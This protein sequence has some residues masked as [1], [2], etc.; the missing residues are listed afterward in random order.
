MKL[1]IAIPSKN[2][3]ETLKKY[4]WA[5]ARDLNHTKKIFVEPQDLNKYLEIC[6]R[7]DIVVLDKD[8]QG[9][10]Y[11][12]QFIQNY[13]KKNGYNLVFK[14]DDDLRGMTEFRTRISLPKVVEKVDR[15]LDFCEEN[16]QK[17]ENLGAIAL[18]YS[19][20]MFEERVWLPAKKVQSSYVVRTDLLCT[21]YNFSVFED[22]A[23]G[24][25]CLVNNY[26]LF[27]YGLMGQDLGVKVGGGTGGHQDFDREKLALE[28]AELLRK[29]YPPITFKK[30]DKP[31]KI[32]PDMRSVK[33]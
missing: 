24:I 25:N 2:R 7:D 33:L 10:G 18:P 26:K 29:L 12:K 1:L 8:N 3:I 13:A 20:Q 9:L 30:V 31:W 14:L 23:V 22:F 27:K 32:E 4:T 16:F 21:P 11:A 28:D 19:F 15:F 5:W 6:F 17:S